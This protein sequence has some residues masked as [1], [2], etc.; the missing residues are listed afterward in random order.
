MLGEIWSTI[1]SN[2]ILNLM[3]LMYH[4]LGDNLGL[5]ILGIATIVRLSLIPLV[6]RQ[7][8]MTKKMASLKPELDKLQKKYGN[9]KKKLGEEQVKLYR[10]VGYNPL[11]CIGTFIPQIIILSA[12]IGVVRAVIG[13]EL[14]GL[15]PWVQN[16]TS[17]SDGISIQTRF[18][19]WDLTKSYKD[20][21][22]EFGRISSEAIPYIGLSILVGVTQFFASTFTQKIQGLSKPDKGKKKK[23]KKKEEDPTEQM[24]KSMQKS[25]KFFLPLMTAYISIT[26]PAALGWYWFVQSFLLVIQ[27]FLLDFDKTKAGVQN[28]WDVLTKKKKKE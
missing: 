26:Y 23:N 15:Y 22:S 7:T 2:P 12:L 13:N 19:I 11:G 27:Y 21:S 5:A 6:K 9:N 10:K 17:M 14:E 18:L 28:M 20:I 8:N 25:T 3:I 16:L 24:Q 1:V 4:F